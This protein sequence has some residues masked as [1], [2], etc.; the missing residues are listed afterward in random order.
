MDWLSDAM[1]RDSDKWSYLEQ[2]MEDC[3]YD[4]LAELDWA[5]E[6]Y[7]MPKLRA[8]MHHTNNLFE[9]E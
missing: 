5:I 4:E 8:L 9:S 2:W 3:Y 7:S 6:G 1:R